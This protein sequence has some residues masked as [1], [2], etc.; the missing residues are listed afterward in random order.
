M[1]DGTVE[2][3][4]VK[5]LTHDLAKAARTMTASEARYLVDAFY[6][7]QEDRK[8][9]HNQSRTQTETQQPTMMID[10]LARQS[11]LLETQIK[12]ALDQ[13]T[14]AHAMGA[15]LRTVHGIG[16]VLAAGLLAYLDIEKAPTV[17]HFWRYAGLDPTSKWEKGQRCPW[18]S[19]LKV[20][21][22]KVGQSFMKFSNAEACDYGRVYRQRKAYEIARNESGGNAE[23]AAAWLPRVGVAT[24][25]HGH[26]AAGHL[27]P[28][29][30][31]ARARRYAV[32]LFLA[33]FHGVWYQLHY[34]KAPPLPYPIARLSEH[35][36]FI[37]PFN[38]L[39]PE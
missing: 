16:P 12:R 11:D 3:E 38:R 5:R 2:P 13:Y 29:Q 24:E 9:A 25:A 36:H 4:S 18:N 6:M 32:K 37:A 39:E 7:M 27:P 34:R 19:N 8:R 22:W 23:T 14:Q 10:W 28:S 33:H 15:W 35:T 17:G 20:L 30:I 21:C 31:D 1:L 26:Y